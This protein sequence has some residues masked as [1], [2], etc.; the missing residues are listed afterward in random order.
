MAFL[1]LEIESA[2][3]AQSCM[4]AKGKVA[5]YKQQ[6]MLL[7]ICKKAKGDVAQPPM[8]ERTDFTPTHAAPKRRR[9]PSHPSEYAAGE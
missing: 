4:L 3:A 7:E 8:V 1:D 6:R 9:S 5:L 2:E